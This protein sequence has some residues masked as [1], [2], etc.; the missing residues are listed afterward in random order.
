[1]SMIRSAGRDRD[2]TKALSLLG[3]LEKM[4]EPLLFF[5]EDGLCGSS[6]LLG[7]SA[8]LGLVF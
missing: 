6:P 3:E 8:S 4:P 7:E 1:M 5:R 2:V